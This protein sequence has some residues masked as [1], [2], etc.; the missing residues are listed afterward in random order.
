MGPICDVPSSLKVSGP[1]AD[2]ENDRARFTTASERQCDGFA[3]TRGPE[4]A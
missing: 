1:F 2:L 3:D 4:R